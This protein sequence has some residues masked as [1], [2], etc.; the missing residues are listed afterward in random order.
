MDPIN[1]FLINTEN[2]QAP[3]LTDK[4]SVKGP[5]VSGACIEGQWKTGEQYIVLLSSDSPFDELIAICL[6]SQKLDLL[7]EVHIGGW[8]SNGLVENISVETGHLSF[9]IFGYNWTV[10]SHEHGKYITYKWLP[11]IARRPL[12]QICKKRYLAV[13]STE[14]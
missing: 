1:R 11:K 4:S 8:Y 6:L 14:L 2:P 12:S 3:L 13:S 10:T 7:D 9:D 5:G